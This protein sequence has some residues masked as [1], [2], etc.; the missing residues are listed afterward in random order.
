MGAAKLIAPFG[1]A[2]R[3]HAHMLPF[4]R[5]HAFVPC[6]GR[7]ASVDVSNVE[8]FLYGQGKLPED[9]LIIV[10][11]TG[12]T[13]E[14]AGRIPRFTYIVEGANSFFTPDARLL[15][16]TRGVCVIRDASANKGGVTASS[17]EVMAALALTD[18]EHSEHMCAAPGADVRGAVGAYRGWEMGGCIGPAPAWPGV[19]LFYARYV[20]DAQDTIAA[21][22]ASEFD[23]L[24]REKEASGKAMPQLTVRTLPSAL[25]AHARTTT[26]PPSHYIYPCRTC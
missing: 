13:V 6:G 15:L 1:V 25:H 9:A 20:C 23:A 21:N 19:P 24:W 4:L 3:N 10:P 11:R 7:P 14:V 12:A 22:A 5:A 2:F 17:L 18:R 26:H 8:S 16:D